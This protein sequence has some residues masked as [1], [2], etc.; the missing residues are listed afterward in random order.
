MQ[1][2]LVKNLDCKAKKAD[3]TCPQFYVFTQNSNTEVQCG[4]V[5]H[6][7]AL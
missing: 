7:Y 5:V 1:K 6:F 3:P 2:E 4:I